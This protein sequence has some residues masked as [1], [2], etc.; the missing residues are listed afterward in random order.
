MLFVLERKGS[1][2]VFSRKMMILIVVIVS[3]SRNVKIVIVSF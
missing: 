1:F 3:R 2:E